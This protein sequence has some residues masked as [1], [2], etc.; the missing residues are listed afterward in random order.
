[1]TNAHMMLQTRYGT[2]HGWNWNAMKT[3][4]TDAYLIAT[5]P[6]IPEGHVIFHNKLRKDRTMR[7]K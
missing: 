1:M 5:A 4:S 6:L 2:H 7:G 3:S